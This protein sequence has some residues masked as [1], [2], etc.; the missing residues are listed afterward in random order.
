MK[1]FPCLFID[2]FLRTNSIKEI[3]LLLN[4]LDIVYSQ[5][6]TVLTI[7]THTKAIG[8]DEKHVHIYPRSP[9]SGLSQPAKRKNLK[10]ILSKLSK[11]SDCLNIREFLNY[12]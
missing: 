11:S 12:E 6:E 10:I 5:K 2:K 1:E 3:K 8:G 7:I 9:M 4:Y